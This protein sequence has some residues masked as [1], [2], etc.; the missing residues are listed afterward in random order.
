MHLVCRERGGELE[1]ASRHVLAADDPDVGRHRPHLEI[2]AHHDDDG[3][4]LDR[5]A[6]GRFEDP[7]DG[8]GFVASDR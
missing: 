1:E 5:T 2:S 4:H 8:L 3:L 7:A 6:D